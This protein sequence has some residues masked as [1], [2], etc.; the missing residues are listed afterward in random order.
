MMRKATREALAKAA[1][2]AAQ[3]PFHGYIQGEDSNLEPI[4]RPFPKWTLKEADGLWCAAFVY[5]CCRKA[6]FDIPI[7]PKECTTCHLAG[8]VAWEEFA[9][10]DSRI[11]YQPGENTGFPKTGD[12]VLYDR[13]FCNQPHDHMGIIVQKMDKMLIVAEGNVQNQS[14]IIHR[15][16]DAHIRAFIRLP[17][18]YRYEQRTI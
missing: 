13:V 6:G 9:K 2:E 17:D 11:A 5:Y 12:I 3:I 18:G 15:P 7:R 16:L 1:G 14:G 10:G 4:I 8:C